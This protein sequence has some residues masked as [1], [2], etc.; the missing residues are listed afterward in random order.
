MS[1]PGTPQVSRCS[2]PIRRTIVSETP[3]LASSL[4]PAGAFN[5]PVAAPTVVVGKPVGHSISCPMGA[6]VGHSASCPAGPSVCAKVRDSSQ[7]RH[8]KLVPT[9]LISLPTPLRRSRQRS[10][11]QRTV[12]ETGG[13]GVRTPMMSRTLSPPML[14]LPAAAPV[15]IMP[16]ELP[17]SFSHAE[18]MVNSIPRTAS[19]PLTSFRRG[20]PMRRPVSDAF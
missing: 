6:P 1:P 11:S 12:V 15:V 13:S 19:I 3:R 17:Q 10:P 9:T 8:C 14:K 2:T 20:S 16:A 4:Q 5:W 18:P 7:Q